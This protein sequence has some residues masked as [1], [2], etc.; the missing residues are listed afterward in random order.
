MSF[1]WFKSH[2]ELD[3]HPKTLHFRS[4]MDWSQNETVGFLH[5]FWWWA[6]DYAPDGVVSDVCLPGVMEGAFGLGRAVGKKVIENLKVSGWLDSLDNGNLFIHNHE[7]RRGVSPEQQEKTRDRVRKHRETKMKRDSNDDV[8]RYSNDVTLLDKDPDTQNKETNKTQGG[9]RGDSD[10]IPPE[11]E[12]QGFLSSFDLGSRLSGLVASSDVPVHSLDTVQVF[13][14]FRDLFL[15]NGI[16]T[17]N[18]LSVKVVKCKV[19]PSRW[20][21]MFLDKVQYAHE[22]T[23]ADPVALTIS[24]FKRNHSPS[25]AARGL[26]EE[27]CVDIMGNPDSRGK[28]WALLSRKTVADELRKRKQERGNTHDQELPSL[29]P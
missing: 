19:A 12:P 17:R 8:T 7:K 27:I 22:K 4:L 1:D 14:V 10:D 9:C 24:G 23:D 5:R 2:K 28:R 29:P 21:T 13:A 6:L 16:P 26:Y 18:E 20:T 25:D 3:R 15:E 11:A